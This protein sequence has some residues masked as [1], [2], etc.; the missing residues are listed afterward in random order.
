MYTT[1]YEKNDIKI[2]DLSHIKLLYFFSEKEPN[3]ELNE[4]KTDGWRSRWLIEKERRNNFYY[5]WKE[6]LKQESKSNIA[7]IS[8]DY[9]S[10]RLISGLRKN[11]FRLQKFLSVTSW[12]GW[13]ATKSDSSALTQFLA[14]NCVWEITFLTPADLHTIINQKTFLSSSSSASNLHRCETSW[15]LC[16]AESYFSY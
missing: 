1:K 6:T 4:R 15:L 11:F 3:C 2:A 16:E 7:F 10:N 12:L 14:V 9:Y 13:S 8:K 5:A